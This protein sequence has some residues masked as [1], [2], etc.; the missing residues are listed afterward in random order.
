LGKLAESIDEPEMCRDEAVEGPTIEM[1]GLKKSVD[2]I[3]GRSKVLIILK[4]YD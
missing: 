4:K 1:G 2:M 3:E